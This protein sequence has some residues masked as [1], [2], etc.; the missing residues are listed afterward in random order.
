MGKSLS[1]WALGLGH[2]EHTCGCVT[3]PSRCANTALVSLDV[4]EGLTTVV[5]GLLSEAGEICF[6]RLLDVEWG[7][8]W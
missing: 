5:P 1:A 6:C 8:K 3:A 4:I 7:E 2:H